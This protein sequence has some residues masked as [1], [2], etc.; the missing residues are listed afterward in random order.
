MAAGVDAS[1][2]DVAV[3]AEGPQ[4]NLADFKG[5]AVKEFTKT[6]DTFFGGAKPAGKKDK[7]QEKKKAAPAVIGAY[8]HHSS[9]TID[10]L[11][12]EFYFHA[13]LSHS[14]DVFAQ[15]K[16]IHYVLISYWHYLLWELSIL[17][18]ACH[19]SKCVFIPSKFNY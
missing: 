10:I 8:T 1:N 16:V 7:K 14:P 3:V 15:F 2:S 12:L 19:A 9:I 13:A 17:H 5:P 4:R 18:H 11:C 6:D